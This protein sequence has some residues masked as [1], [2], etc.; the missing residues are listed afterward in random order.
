MKK[1]LMYYIT[2]M[3]TVLFVLVSTYSYAAEITKESLTKFFEDFVKKETNEGDLEGSIEV[4]DAEIIIESQQ[5]EYKMQY[6]LTDKPTFTIDMV[7]KDGMT[8]DEC[9]EEASKIFIPLYGFMAV[10]GI[11]GADA[12]EAMLYG[13]FSI[14][15]KL[16]E[17]GYEETTFTEENFVNATDYAQKVYSKNIEIVDDL[18]TLSIKKAELKGEEYIIET[19]LVVNSEKDFSVLNGKADEFGNTMANSIIG[20]LSN[21]IGSMANEIVAS[22]NTA[23]NN[24]VNSIATST[25]LPTSSTA[26]IGTMP[27]AGVEIYA[28]NILKVVLGL[29]LAGVIVYSVYNK[30]YSS[31]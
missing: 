11:N 22:T 20:G 15:E 18:Y 17:Q 13:M 31:K 10:A 8:Y 9:S 7:F 26:N 25:P 27:N 3:L 14:M 19:E 4:N 24:T 21:S 5:E 2:I 29:S 6:D 16:S 12:D 30:R 1:T 23:T 28:L